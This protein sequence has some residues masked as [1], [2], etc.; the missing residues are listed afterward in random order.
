MNKTQQ[1]LRNLLLEG[2]KYGD[3]Y[4]SRATFDAA[5]RVWMNS[6][7]GKRALDIAENNIEGQGFMRGIFIGALI[8]VFTFI[9]VAT[10]G[11]LISK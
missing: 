6:V 2:A 5:V 7:E 4:Y 8:T 9:L 3:L 11:F 10:I 1:Q